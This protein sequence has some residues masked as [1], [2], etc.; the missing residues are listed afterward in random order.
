MNRVSNIFN[1]MKIKSE[2]LK[3]RLDIW[4]D[5]MNDLIFK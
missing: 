5:Q 2:N 1:N 4:V 3:L